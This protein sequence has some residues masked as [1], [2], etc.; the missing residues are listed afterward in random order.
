MPTPP[1]GV[2]FPRF[3]WEMYQPGKVALSRNGP[4]R[5]SVHCVADFLASIGFR[6]E[7][8]ERRR[9]ETGRILRA[10]LD[11]VLS[12]NKQTFLN[13]NHN[14]FNKQTETILSKRQN[15]FKNRNSIFKKNSLE[16]KKLEQKKKVVRKVLTEFKLM[17]FN[18]YKHTGILWDII[19]FGR[20][21]E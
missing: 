6:R 4:E 2:W 15:T 17:Q 21:R 7:R 10:H 19:E 9:D 11:I 1:P 12:K 18:S 13:T 5:R 14:N 3:F 8:G 16:Q 20:I